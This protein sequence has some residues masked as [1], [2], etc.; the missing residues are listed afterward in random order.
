MLRQCVLI[1]FVAYFYFSFVLFAFTHAPIPLFS[2]CSFFGKPVLPQV[3]AQ[4]GTELELLHRELDAA[5]E[6]AEILANTVDEHIARTEAEVQRLDQKVK[7]KGEI[8][9]EK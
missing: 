9:I 3:A 4:H 8:E 1:S 6:A 7:Y 2:I 5:N